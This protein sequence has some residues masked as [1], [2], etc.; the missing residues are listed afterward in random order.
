MSQYVVSGHLEYLRDKWYGSSPCFRLTA[1][2]YRP[3]PLE[4]QT[5]AGVFLMLTLGI[6]I[7]IIILLLE[8]IVYRYALPSLRTKPK[9]SLWRNRN[10]MFFSQVSLRIIFS[11]ENIPGSDVTEVLAAFI[12]VTSVPTPYNGKNSLAAAIG[13]VEQTAVMWLETSIKPPAPPSGFS[14]YPLTNSSWEG[15]CRWWGSNLRPS[16]RQSSTLL[17]HTDSGNIT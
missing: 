9:D 15:E 12:E 4:I 16:R 5:V 14:R 8:H 1:D 3:Q 2:I 17:V 11:G 7:G 13:A 10:L 6:F